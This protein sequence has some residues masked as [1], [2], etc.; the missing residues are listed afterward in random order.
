[1][2]DRLRVRLKGVNEALL[3]DLSRAMTASTMDAVSGRIG[4]ALSGDGAGAHGAMAPADVLTGF[5]GLLQANE[6]ALEDGTWSWKQGARRAAL[7]PRALRGRPR[8]GRRGARDRLGR[9]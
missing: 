1:M 8:H 4:Q 2:L 5:A 3:P 7:R 9:G 6:Q